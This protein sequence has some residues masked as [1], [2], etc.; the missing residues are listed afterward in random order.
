MKVRFGRKS[1]K[2]IFKMK[3]RELKLFDL[4]LGKEHKVHLCAY[5]KCGTLVGEGSASFR[6]GKLI[7]PD[8]CQ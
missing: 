5:S 7:I 2:Y 1:T 8:I 3:K 4:K 6:T